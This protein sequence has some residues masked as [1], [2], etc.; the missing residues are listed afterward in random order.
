M[1]SRSAP[2]TLSTYE[3]PAGRRRLGVGAH[4]AA[5]SP[6]ACRRRSARQRGLDLVDVRVPAQTRVIA[7]CPRSRVIV[8]SVRLAPGRR[9][10]RDVGDD[11]GRSWPMTVIASSFTSSTHAR[12]RHA[13]AG[14]RAMAT[15]DL[16]ADAVAWYD[17]NA[18]D[19][20]WRTAGRDPVGRPGQRGHAPADTGHPGT[21]GVAGLDATVAHPGR[22]GRRPARRGDPDVGPARLPPPGAAAARMRGG[23]RRYA[24]RLRPVRAGHA[25]RAARSRQLHGA[26]GGRVRVRP[27]PSGRGHQRAPVGRPGGR[28]RCGRRRH[29]H[30]T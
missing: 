16:A 15:S 30:G 3:V 10:P 8:E 4:R 9:A 19:L 5:P 28:R 2:C 7:K 24:R 14:W 17:A 12:I 29:D 22:P 23:D 25:A 1:P 27:A 13:V 21:A 6:A 26:G 18:R 11:A 20:P